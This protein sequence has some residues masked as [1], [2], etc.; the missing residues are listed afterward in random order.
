MRYA[1]EY[2]GERT[3]LDIK[4]GTYDIIEVIEKVCEYEG[5]Q[6]NFKFYRLSDER[7]WIF[8]P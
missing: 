8:T 3:G 2:P 1:P 7:G 4:K 6:V 5:A